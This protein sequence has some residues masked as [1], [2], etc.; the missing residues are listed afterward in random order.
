MLSSRTVIIS[1]YFYIYSLT[2]MEK[3]ET[4]TL[5]LHDHVEEVGNFFPGISFSLSTHLFFRTSCLPILPTQHLLVSNVPFKY[6][7]PLSVLLT[8]DFFHTKKMPD[9]HYFAFLPQ[10]QMKSLESQSTKWF[11]KF[12][13][14][15]RQYTPSLKR[16][17]QFIEF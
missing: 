16:I 15:T 2:P 17:L 13:V 14:S 5:F 9:Q 8:R 4:N 1:L 10:G 11:M 6:K 12:V 7:K 3:T